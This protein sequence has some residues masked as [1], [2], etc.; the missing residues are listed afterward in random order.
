MHNS[1]GVYP[2]WPNRTVD[3]NFSQNARACLHTAVSSGIT[4]AWLRIDLQ[5]VRSIKSVKFWYRNDRADASTNTIRL[6]GYSI[7]GSTNS[8]LSDTKVCYSDSS[9][10]LPTV[11]EAGCKVLTR[12]IWFYQTKSQS[13][14]VPILEICEVQVFGCETGFYGDNCSKSCDHC[15]NNKYCDI[16]TGQCDDLGCALQHQPPSCID[17]IPG[18]HGPK[19]EYHC[20]KFCEWDYCN[21]A[22]GTCLYG[23]DIGYLGSHCNF[24][25]RNRTYGVNCSKQCGGC[26]NGTDCHHISGQCYQG[27]DP[28]W[29][30]TTDCN[31]ICKNQT[32]GENCVYQCDGHCINDEPCNRRDGTCKQ[33]SLGWA[34]AKSLSQTEN[35]NL[36]VTIG[37]VVAVLF[38]LAILVGVVCLYR[39]MHAR[40]EM[41]E[42][43]WIVSWNAA[44]VI[45]DMRFTLC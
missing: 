22:T 24:K 8:L 27:C 13:G 28:G 43:V 44:A 45:F 15:V 30:Q 6:L 29:Y 39:K 38:I 2:Y 26:L 3:G 10:I 35:N 32:F 7:R 21:K 31:V 1:G 23:C 25:C 16:D 9:E 33:C 17:C 37:S 41:S 34:A 12:Y 40:K 18:F 19:C 4:E 36:V 14:E 5:A 42:N 11:I 20:N